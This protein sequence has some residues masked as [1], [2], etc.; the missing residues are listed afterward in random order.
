MA[1]TETGAA[2]FSMQ[3]ARGRAELYPELHAIM[4]G[5]KTDTDEGD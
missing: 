3:L 5:F 1:V 2:E 4:Y